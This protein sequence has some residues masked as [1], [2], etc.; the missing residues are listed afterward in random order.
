KLVKA[1]SLPLTGQGVVDLVITEL[2]VFDVSRGK[3]PLSL[4]QLAP[5]VTAEEVKA[6]TEAAFKVALPA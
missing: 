2:G 3:K 6:K 4:I 1:C 5:G